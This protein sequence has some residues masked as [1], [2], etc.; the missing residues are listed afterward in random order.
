MILQQNY[1]G[2]LLDND[3]R[4]VGQPEVKIDEISEDVL[5]L[6]VTAPVA[7]EVQLGQYKG[8]EV[9]KDTS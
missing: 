1:S 3:I 4:P 9:K 2:I 7:P 8:L 6:T 5:K